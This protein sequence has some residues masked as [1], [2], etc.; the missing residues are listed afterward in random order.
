MTDRSLPDLTISGKTWAD[1][2]FA[3][4]KAH[5]ECYIAGVK[6]A[7]ENSPSARK[8]AMLLGACQE[9]KGELEAMID[10]GERNPRLILAYR[11]MKLA[12]ADAKR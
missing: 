10:Y 3:Q 8:L 6:A 1:E 11:T 12:I 9:A 5:Q 2:L 7:D 4:A